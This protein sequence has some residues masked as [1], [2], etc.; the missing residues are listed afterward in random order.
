MITCILQ[1]SDSAPPKE[2]EEY[3]EKSLPVQLA[4]VGGEDSDI[5]LTKPAN[6]EQLEIV[7]RIEKRDAVLVQGPPGTG[8]THLL[9]ILCR[10][11]QVANSRRQQS[12]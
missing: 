6:R 11:L 4:E 2:Q 1:T 3:E 10:S 9:R 8:R 5:L 12:I 7:R